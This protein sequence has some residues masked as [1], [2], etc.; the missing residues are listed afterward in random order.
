MAILDLKP[1]DEETVRAEAKRLRKKTSN[2]L[3]VCWGAARRGWIAQIRDGD[4]N[5]RNLGVY[6]IQKEA[7]LIRDR[8][9]HRLFGARA[10]LN[11][12][13][14]TGRRVSSGVRR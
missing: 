11:F 8:E 6:R 13:L 7:A 9:A 2:Y 14:G 12:E 10:Q 5:V 4:G 3:G 1:A